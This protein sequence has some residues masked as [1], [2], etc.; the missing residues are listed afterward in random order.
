MGRIAELHVYPIKSCRG[1]RLER[2]L[3]Q[4]QGLQYDREWL[5]TGSD[6]RFITQ[7]EQPRL[8]LV[9]PQVSGD[10]LRVGAPGLADLELPLAARGAP[11]EVTVWRDRC[12]AFDC[13]PQAANW[14]TELLG[15]P[16]RLVRFDPDHTRLSDPQWTQGLPASTR[17]SDGFA[18]LAISLASLQDLNARLPRPLP[19][20]RFRP[21]LVLDAIAAYGEDGL[22]RC[23]I[24]D[25][26]E[27]RAVKACTRC[28]VTTTDQR[29]GV[30]AGDE[31]LRTL[32]SY[33][34]DRALNGVT[35]GQNLIVVR[36][37]GAQLAVGDRLR[38]L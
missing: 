6:G 12:R 19:M 10:T 33:R 14:F 30:A 25:E 26:I 5:V 21:N 18:L 7:R 35:F 15:T 36:G 27:L 37:G 16:A 8:A 31:P 23:A 3:L 1:I 13:G 20:D 17:F 9:A 32:R 28:V 2:A 11:C 4:P 29:T 22:D 24:S 38:S 34:W